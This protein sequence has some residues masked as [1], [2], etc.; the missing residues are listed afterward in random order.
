M[1]SLKQAS[2]NLAFEL[3]DTL[4]YKFQEDGTWCRFDVDTLDD[5]LTIALRK[6]EY[7]STLLLIIK[8]C[9]FCCR[10]CEAHDAQDKK[11]LENFKKLFVRET[12]KRGL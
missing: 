9:V 1:K 6:N 2:L 12:A 8:N 11:A 4:S 3:V 10:I 5:L 7:N